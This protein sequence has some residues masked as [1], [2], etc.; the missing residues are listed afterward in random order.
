MFSALTP[1]W[2]L[3]NIGKWKNLESAGIRW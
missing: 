2:E 3:K 1:G